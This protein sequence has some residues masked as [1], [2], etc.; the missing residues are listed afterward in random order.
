MKP[1]DRVELIEDMEELQAGL[2]GEVVKAMDT[3]PFVKEDTK[4]LAVLFDGYRNPCIGRTIVG[5]YVYVLT[6]CRLA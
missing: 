3:F 5:K 6:K 4:V 2:K 1:G